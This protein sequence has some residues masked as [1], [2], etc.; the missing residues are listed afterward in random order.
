MPVRANTT[1]TEDNIL[2]QIRPLHYA[3]QDR[4][5]ARRKSFQRELSN[6]IDITT[7]DYWLAVRIYV[8]FY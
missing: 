7:A 5:T 4:S 6:T 8:Y 3:I 1:E 2:F